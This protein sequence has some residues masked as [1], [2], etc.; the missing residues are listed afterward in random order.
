MF[1]CTPIFTG[2]M[3]LLDSADALSDARCVCGHGK[4]GASV[5]LLLRLSVRR[6]KVVHSV[7][8]TS[9]LDPQVRWYTPNGLMITLLLT[10][11]LLAVP[12]RI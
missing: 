4:K 11:M 5:Q 2:A 3:K 12:R 8:D 7:L 6:I 9:L 10:I 1:S